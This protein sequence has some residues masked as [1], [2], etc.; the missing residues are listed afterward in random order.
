MHNQ[1]VNNRK[2]VAAGQIDELRGILERI[3]VN[4]FLTEQLTPQEHYQLYDYTKTL[5]VYFHRMDQTVPILRLDRLRLFADHL[6][7]ASLVNPYSFCDCSYEA[8]YPIL[9]PS[10]WLEAF[11]KSGSKSATYRHVSC[12]P[13]DGER[14][15]FGL[16]EAQYRHLFFSYNQNPEWG[17]IKL[18]G[19]SGKKTFINHINQFCDHFEKGAKKC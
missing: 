6:Q 18:S 5:S 16:T 1:G 19:R 15:F 4:G 7:N 3:Q 17:N 9:F 10:D 13:Y 12:S 2:S 11:N 14:F 8:E